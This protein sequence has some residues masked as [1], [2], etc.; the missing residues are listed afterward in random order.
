MTDVD[1][2]YA[3]AR[4]AAEP[5]HVGVDER[6][7]RLADRPD[8]HRQIE[9][10]LRRAYIERRILVGEPLPSRAGQCSSLC[11]SRVQH[12]PVRVFACSPNGA[13]GE[14]VTLESI[15]NPTTSTPLHACVVG[16]TCLGPEL[17]DATLHWNECTA[18]V[19]RVSPVARDVGTGGGVHWCERHGRMHVCTRACRFTMRNQIGFAVCTLSGRTLGGRI[20]ATFGQGTVVVSRQVQY[21]RD[22]EA[23][24]R[25]EA[26][27]VRRSAL[28]A[29]E[30]V[31]ETGSTTVLERS[32]LAAKTKRARPASTTG[33]GR[34]A[35]KTLFVDGGA[36]SSATAA[37]AAAAAESA[38]DDDDDDDDVYIDVDAPASGLFDN[39]YESNTFGEGIADELV[40]WYTQAYAAVHLL[41]FS[42]QRAQIEYTNRQKTYDDVRHRL[43][44]YMAAQRKA[45]APVCLTLMRQVEQKSMNARRIYPVLLLP[46]NGTCRLTSYYALISMEFYLQLVAVVTRLHDRFDVASRA[47]AD[48]LTDLTFASVAPNIVHL[49]HEG[50]KIR[51]QTIVELE[52]TLSIFPESQTIEALGFPQKQC[53]E[54]QKVLKK[55]VVAAADLS[56]P[57][58]SMRTTHVDIMHIIFGSE[59]VVVRFLEERR[60]RLHIE[61]APSSH[62]ATAH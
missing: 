9:A 26:M 24:E 3:L 45:R 32:P 30:N 60:R 6:W 20:D 33:D 15:A 29:V 44:S 7:R 36:P 34:R 28:A 31:V 62:S 25:R 55:C 2:A 40:R 58:E 51:G 54:V 19:A 39:S 46:R 1:E 14:D 11:S 12:W 53:T 27:A 38:V 50:L 57:L 59:S 5:R 8:F 13:L 49:L 52:R 18:D 48:Q 61:D 56:E 22:Q 35:R 16:Q 43:A 41:L 42:K 23:R 17:A 21:Q 47:A 4:L 10:Q 37:A